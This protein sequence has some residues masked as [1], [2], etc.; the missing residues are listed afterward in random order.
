[1]FSIA[2]TLSATS[3]TWEARDRIRWGRGKSNLHAGN[4]R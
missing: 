1:V 3:A 2:A 4:D